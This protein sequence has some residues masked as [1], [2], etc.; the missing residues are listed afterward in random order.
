MTFRKRD[1][2]SKQKADQIR[3]VQRDFQTVFRS[4]PGQ[5]VLAHLA[6]MWC[7]L[8]TKAEYQGQHPEWKEAFWWILDQIGI[9]DGDNI[10]EVIAAL[11][12]IRPAI[13]EVEGPE[14]DPLDLDD[15]DIGDW[16]G[17]TLPGA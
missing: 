13:P 10:Y 17:T 11:M 6:F 8:T 15:D 4:K 2:V 16:E 7:A 9:N 1:R 3:D 12:K 14:P 5:R